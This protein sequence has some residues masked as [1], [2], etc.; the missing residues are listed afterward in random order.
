MIVERPINDYTFSTLEQALGAYPKA[1]LSMNQVLS[2]HEYG[3]IDRPI[4]HSAKTP[5][6]YS[7]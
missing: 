6:Q 7:T 1:V 3:E 5:S 4:E 2:Y